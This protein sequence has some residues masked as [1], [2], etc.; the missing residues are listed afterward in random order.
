MLKHFTSLN[1]IQD[2]PQ[3]LAV[4]GAKRDQGPGR[5]P[6]TSTGGKGWYTIRNAHEDEAE[7][8]I[9]DEIGYWGVTANDFIGDLRDIKA[10]K[11]ALHINSPGGDVFDGIA[12]YNALRR[13]KADITVWIDGIA[14]SAASFIAMAGDEVVMSPHSQMMI[15]EASGL[16][17]G[18]ADDMR[19][20]AEILD[21]SSDNIASI[22]AKRAGDDVAEWRQ[23][24]K[25]ESWFSDI[26]AVEAGLADRVDGEDEEA[27]AARAQAAQTAQVPDRDHLP[28][29][30]ALREGTGDR[31][32]EPT[33]PEFDWLE[34]VKEAVAV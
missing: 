11:I 6:G 20:M 32:K 14:A 16:V 29:L 7:I 10:G 1:P 3:L 5:R 18:A 26:E 13:H 25:D 17:I 33:L 30:A 9:Y 4:L 27:V 22:Y 12:I 28:T 23:R 19:K 24:M 34:G 21:K 31:R 15:H 8:Y 2:L